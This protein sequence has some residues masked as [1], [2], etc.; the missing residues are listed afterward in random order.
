MKERRNASCDWVAGLEEVAALKHAG[1]ARFI[2]LREG[3]HTRSSG[4]LFP[5]FFDLGISFSKFWN[6]RPPI[7]KDRGDLRLT[8][9]FRRNGQNFAHGFRNGISGHIRLAGHR[10]AEATE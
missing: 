10:E 1:F 5:K 6:R 4:P 3:E 8:S 9:F 7:T 2:T